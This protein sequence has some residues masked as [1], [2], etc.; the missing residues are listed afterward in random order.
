MGKPK[1]AI[2]GSTGMLGAITLDSFVKSGEFDVIA[3]A[4]RPESL[5]ELKKRYPDVDFRELDAQTADL[6][7][8]AGTIKGAEWVVNAIGIIKPYIH[9]DNAEEVERAIQV[10]AFFPHLLAKAAKRIDAKVIQ[11]ATDCV[12]SGAKGRYVEADLH[13]ALDVYGK[14][15]SL[16]EVYMDNVCH[17]RCSIIGPELSAHVSLM[18]WFLGQ[19]RNAEVNGFTNHQWNGVTTLHF[20]RICQGIIKRNIAVPHLQHVIPGNMINKAD[21]LKSFSKEFNRQDITINSVKAPKIIDRTLMTGDEKLN[22]DIWRAAGYET[23]PTIELMV[24]E[25]AR[26][27]FPEGADTP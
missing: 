16:G 12:Y 14:T 27:G 23:P 8:I 19:P 24:A 18:D 15:K 7:T 21:L 4:R 9:D 25:I 11:I 5:A 1:V 3:T 10:N 13:D 20:A 6:E 26:Y 22:K 17:V 2:L